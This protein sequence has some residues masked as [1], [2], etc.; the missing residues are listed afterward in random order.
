MSPSIFK[1]PGLI[2]CIWEWTSGKATYV[3]NT[4]WLAYWTDL[5]DYPGCVKRL[6]EDLEASMRDVHEYRE[7]P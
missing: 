5:A 4:V 3:G 7:Q 2:L 6:L 1:R